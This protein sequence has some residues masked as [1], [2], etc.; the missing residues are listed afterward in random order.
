MPNLFQQKYKKKSNKNL[1]TL[2]KPAPKKGFGPGPGLTCF[3][4]W[5]KMLH[6]KSPTPDLDW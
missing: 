4:S 2:K 5:A 6:S 1:L 3:A